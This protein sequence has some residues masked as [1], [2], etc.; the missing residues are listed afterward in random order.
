MADIQGASR[1]E[2][3]A[4][5]RARRKDVPRGSHAEWTPPPGRRPVAELLADQERTRVPDLV[6]LRH[7]RMSASPFAFY[8]GA[9]AV[10]AADL[11]GEPRTGLD[12]Q[13]CGDAHLANLGGYASPDRQLVFDINDFDETLPGPF[14]WDVKRLA[15][16][17]EVAGRSNG[18]DER[19]RSSVVETLVRTYAGAL[20]DFSE[21]GGLELWYSRLTD[22]DV[23]ERWGGDASERQ[24]A[25]FRKNVTKA[26][27]KD[28]VKA[29][30]RLTEDVDGEL[31]FRTDPP[32]LVPIVDLFGEDEVSDLRHM[33]GHA[34]TAYQRTL[35]PDR[36]HLL[37]RY[38]FVDLA[39]KVVGVGSVGTRCWVAL[40]V[41]TD[42]GDALF[43]QIKEAEASVLEAHLG[44]SGYEQH[45]QRVVEGQRLVQPSSDIFLGWERVA[46]VDG[47]DHDYYVRQLWD[48]KFSPA[49]DSMDAEVLDVYAQIC[50]TIL[51]RA[52]ARTGDAIAI[53]SYVGKGGPFARAM[54]EFAH[55][56]AD[57]NERDHA[58]FVQA[59][60]VAAGA[61]A[62]ASGAT[63]DGAAPL[64]AG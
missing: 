57:Q 17:F 58:D 44:R 16:S 61:T 11:A 39:R 36:R 37:Q 46:G 49:I 3:A 43:L 33:I 29:L 50:G 52:H 10:Q 15:A 24:V 18:F 59:V 31:R 26:R 47:R 42:P 64:A 20:G 63:A 34:L 6:P 5:G 60:S 28:N 48:W 2:R 27:S 25:R 54:A 56:Y 12:V 51:A 55:S 9:A 8:R 53:S 45:G 23:A 4:E 38:R 32:V 40:M 19:T 13:L 35:Q 1:A 30:G 14:E 62:D 41:G 21:M 22:Q 7:E